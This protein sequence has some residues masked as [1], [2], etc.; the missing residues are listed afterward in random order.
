[1]Y[2]KLAK[3]DLLVK[4]A[5]YKNVDQLLTEL[6]EYCSEV[7]VTFARKAISAVGRIA[8]KLEEAAER[9]VLAF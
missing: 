9:C 4:L 3:L 6:K 5:D 2:V 7:D 8:I 1:M